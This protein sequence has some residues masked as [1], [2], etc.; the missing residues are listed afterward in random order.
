MIKSIFVCV[1]ADELGVE[2]ELDIPAAR[3]DVAVKRLARQTGHLVIFQSADIEKI[4][5]TALKGRFTVQQALDKLFNNTALSGGLT[6]RGVITVSQK[7]P[8][9]NVGQSMKTKKNLLATFVSLFVS[10]GGASVALAQDNAAGQASSDDSPNMLLEEVV[11]TGVRAS[12]KKNLDM[13]RDSMAF[14]DAITAEDIGKF[15]DKNV[16]DALQRIPGVSITRSG[17]EGQFVSIRGTGSDLTLTQLNGNYVATASTNRDP[18]RSFN[19]SLLPANLIERTEVYK[20]PEAKIDEGGIGG[21]VIVH[22]RRPFNMEANSGFLNFEETYSDVSGEMEPQYSGLY[23]W[24]N[25]SETF[26]FLV[27]YTSQD[28]TNITESMTTENWQLFDDAQYEPD[29]PFVKE[30]LR[31]TDGNE[32]KG[33]A[34]FA[35]VQKRNQEARDRTGYQV[36]LQW[37]PTERITS[38]FNY[39]GAD[40]SQNNDDDLVLLAEWDYRDPAIVP[41]SVR[42]DG[43]TIVAMQL[44]DPDLTDG[45]D[46]AI[47]LQAPAVGSRRQLSESESDTYDLEVIY[48]ADMYTA[49]INLGYTESS[50]GSSMNNL[51]RFYGTGGVT[52]S[53]G[54][55]LNA[56]TILNYDAEPSDFNGF[57]WRS[58][59]AGISKDEEAYIQFDLNVELEVGIFTSFDVG[60]KYRD[61][62]INRRFDNLVWDDGIPDNATLWG[63]CCGLGY[64]WWHHD[65]NIPD[66]SQ[67]ANFIK[68]IDGLTGKAGTQKSFL[69]VDWDAY[70]NWLDDNFTRYRRDDEGSYFKINEEITAV[71]LQGN[72][73]F[74]NIEGN[75]GL[76]VVQTDQDAQ[77]LGAGNGIN[78][79]MLVTSSSSYTDY[80]PSFNLKWEIIDD[81]ILRAAAAKTVARVSYADL[82]T[83]ESFNDPTDG[84]NETSGTQG[85][86]NLKP[87]EATQYDIGIEWYFADASAVG[88]TLFHKEIDSYVSDGELVETRYYPKEDRDIT[89]IFSA[90]VNG[91]DA[92]STGLELFYQHAFDFGGGIIANYTYTDTSLATVDSGDGTSKE[93]PLPGTSENQ[94]NLSAYYENDTFSV[95]ASYNYRDGY[96]EG[97]VSSGRDIYRDSYGQLDLNASYSITENL[98]LTASVVNMLEETIER[99]W[100][101]GDRLYERAYNGRRFYTGVNYKF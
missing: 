11:V 47:D 5:T 93:R 65:D 12:L 40:L 25:E 21:T 100:G 2:Y 10:S 46:G 101:E 76:R 37:A 17:G 72:Y 59:D 89:V 91:T 68:R 45:A 97:L 83:S 7:K 55:D 62:E 95:R 75:I 15:P 38:T 81:L 34:P 19:Y 49:V 71:Y 79:G 6:R 87:F 27:S 77:S 86:V 53:Y 98:Q 52:E 36:T 64:E 94:Y 99:Y 32:I 67:F 51:Q 33:Y 26:G 43:D 56:D 20:S 3:A 88:A 54:W 78:A 57:G 48:Q 13:K 35:V 42:Y 74:N 85:N 16:A 14:V 30:S 82:G 50:G 1:Q 8:N 39:I 4:E 9:K 18:S 61:H 41:G 70:T 22:T 23:S 96:A 66:P 92:T 90:P 44:A 69:T 63:G 58:T 24:K 28:R 73:E 60:A 80:L 84:N 29:K 31:D